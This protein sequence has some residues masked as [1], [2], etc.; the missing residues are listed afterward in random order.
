MAAVAVCRAVETVSGDEAQRPEIKWVNDIFIG[1]RKI[2]G[3]LTEA[4][5]DVESG[6]IESLVLG[7]GVNIN[8]S[9]EEFPEEL[10][11]IAG[12]LKMPPGDRA[13]FAAALIGEVFSR[14]EALRASKSGAAL[15]MEEY[16]ARSMMV[17][18][19]VTVVKNA[20]SQAAVSRGIADDGSLIVEYPDSATEQLRF[21]EVSITL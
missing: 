12:S 11:G 20:Q 21:G 3:I 17:D 8:V 7:I 10:R 16:R 9:D 15:I 14:Y 1:G 2:C 13:R 4:V 5:S 6:S 19:A 18:R